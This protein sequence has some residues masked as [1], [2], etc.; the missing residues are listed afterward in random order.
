MPYTINEAIQ[1]AISFANRAIEADRRACQTN[2][3]TSYETAESNYKQAIELYE[4]SYNLESN[5]ASKTLLQK[6]L[7]V[8]KNRYSIMCDWLELYRAERTSFES[9]HQRSD[10]VNSPSTEPPYLPSYTSPKIAAR[11]TT[12]PPPHRLKL[13]LRIADGM[14]APNGG[15]GSTLSASSV[16]QQRTTDLRARL[17]EAVV[18]EKP[19]V[20]WDDV[21]GL[22][23]AKETMMEAT[24]LHDLMPHVYGSER[25]R[26][27]TI[28]LYGAPGV[29][30]TLLAKAVATANRAKFYMVTMY[31][32]MAKLEC[33]CEI[34]VK[35]LFSI[36]KEDRKVVVFFD[37]VDVLFS[38]RDNESECLRRMRVQFMR[39]LQE[40]QQSNDEVLLLATS[41][42]PWTLEEAF[43]RR[44]DRRIYIPLP[45]KKARAHML[46]VQLQNVHHNITLDE[47]ENIA[48][49]YE[50][51]TGADIVMLVRDA[52]MEP[53]RIIKN[54]SFFKQ[55]EVSE[56]GRKVRKMT[57][58]DRED[59]G[60]IEMAFTSVSTKELCAPPVTCLDFDLATQSTKPTS[61]KETIAKHEEFTVKHGQN[62]L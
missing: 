17:R 19:T 31:D 18:A 52:A 8:Y 2:E 36:A 41:R 9:Q 51:Y 4:Y 58:C 14:S 39:E 48:E 6:K 45:D 27:K 55:I 16:E 59:S 13:P 34:M 44:M 47:I 1:S 56:Y 23:G 60:A 43:L 21:V 57:P 3:V 12:P 37:D 7:T 54:A 40:L 26:W 32:L 49:E 33:D 53:V 25:K 20:T 50:G 24:I 30:K 62:G 15:S 42:S 38:N 11:P 46:E 29:G 28:L 35:T 22:A 10:F 61:G 5:P